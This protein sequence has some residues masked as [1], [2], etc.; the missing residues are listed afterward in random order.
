LSAFL[1]IHLEAVEY[2]R[3]T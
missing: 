1:G 2:L 3:I